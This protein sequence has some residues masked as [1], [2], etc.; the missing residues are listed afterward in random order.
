MSSHPLPISELKLFVT[1]GS[2]TYE[3]V[4]PTSTSETTNS[5]QITDAGILAAFNSQA[6]GTIFNP[7]IVT[8]Y[9]PGTFLSGDTI[10]TPSVVASFIARVI[11]L[12]DIPNKLTTDASF[13]LVSLSLITTISTGALSYSSSN[14][15]VATVNSSGQVTPVGEGTT[16]ITV[17][18][19]A[20]ANHPAGSASATFTVSLA[21]PPISRASNNVTIQYTGAAGDVPTLSP[22]LIEAN[23]RGTGMEW[24]AVVKQGM[25]QAITDYAKETS[26]TPF[27]RIPGDNSTLVQFN[28]IVTTLMTDMYNM[29]QNCTAF[30]QNI[31]SWD[32]S[33]VTDMGI[34]FENAATFNYDISE[35][36]TSLVTNTVSMFQNA[37]AFNQNIGAW[38]TSNVTNMFG[39]FRGANLFNNGG[40]SSIGNW[41]T[42]KV[43]NMALM[44][45]NAAAFNQNLSGWN[46]TITS[47][48]PSL[49]RILFA[50]GS[51]LALPENSHKLPPF[52]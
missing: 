21:P 40:N 8:T 51:P 49:T 4:I 38:N 17:N 42:S 43:V 36:D 28:N 23:L 52:V 26:N 50:D 11:S 46:V 14:T 5:F 3:Q 9:A 2:N 10:T 35:W 32:T 27:V 6:V 19:A 18:Q 25:K 30:N 24:F 31:G 39:M 20:T 33:K 13:N 15:S 29:F 41:N 44:F 22:L 1:Q 45:Y 37:S 7:S 47:S 48:R 12:S 34:M 16:T